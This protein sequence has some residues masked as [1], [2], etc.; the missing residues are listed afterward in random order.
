MERVSWYE[1]IK[2]GSTY[3]SDVNL[4]LNRQ[5]VGLIIISLLCQS[6]FRFFTI[7]PL[8]GERRLLALDIV[9]RLQ[10]SPG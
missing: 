2:L 7:Y 5:E 4:R 9:E 8:L 10:A 1:R 3:V 6:A